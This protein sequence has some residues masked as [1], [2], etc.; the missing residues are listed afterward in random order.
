MKSKWLY[1][2]AKS[3]DVE[4]DGQLDSRYSPELKRSV[5]GPKVLAPEKSE[6]FE[7][8]KTRNKQKGQPL[9]WQADMSEKTKYV[10]AQRSGDEMT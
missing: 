3:A 2:Q 10:S 7:A 8:L 5:R 9:R 6:T 4:D 1:I